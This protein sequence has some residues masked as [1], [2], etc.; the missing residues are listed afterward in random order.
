MVRCGQPGCYHSFHLLATLGWCSTYQPRDWN[1]MCTLLLSRRCFRDPEAGST[2]IFALSWHIK[3]SQSG[4]GLVFLR[5]AETHIAVSGKL[6]GNIS[7][8]S[9]APDTYPSPQAFSGFPVVLPHNLCDIVWYCHSRTR[10]PH[11]N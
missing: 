8:E 2:T 4:R 5:C 11:R 9:T 6:K 7:V 10:W 1:Q 3:W